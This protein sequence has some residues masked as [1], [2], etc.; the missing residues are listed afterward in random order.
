MVGMS[1]GPN[2]WGH[3][4]GAPWLYKF[5]AVVFT[6]TQHLAGVGGD[7]FRSA[8][9]DGHAD[10]AIM[11]ANAPGGVGLRLVDGSIIGK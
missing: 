5:G 3:A 1:G 4:V 8:L 10:D 2:D 11:V 6:H 7:S 9:G